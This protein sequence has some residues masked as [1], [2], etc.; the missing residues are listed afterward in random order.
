MNPIKFN[1]TRIITPGIPRIPT[2]R[3]VIKLSGIEI[4]RGPP[5]LFNNQITTIPS[6]ILITRPINPLVFILKTNLAS[7]NTT[8]AI[9][10]IVK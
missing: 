8:T 5:N 7:N 1:S 3:A 6:K 10:I 2:I 9:K 4:P